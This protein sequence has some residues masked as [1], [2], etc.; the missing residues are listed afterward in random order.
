MCLRRLLKGVWEALCCQEAPVVIG[1]WNAWWVSLCGSAPTSSLHTHSCTH[2]YWHAWQHLMHRGCG[3]KKLH[4]KTRVHAIIP[5]NLRRHRAVPPL[6][7]LLCRLSRICPHWTVDTV[8]DSLFSDAFIFWDRRLLWC[9]QREETDC[10]RSERA[11]SAG[12]SDWGWCLP[13]SCYFSLFLTHYFC[14]LTVFLRDLSIFWM[15]DWSAECQV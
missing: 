15:V 10:F 8:T 9:D 12:M 7:W 6:L 13:E 4:K 5:L 14:L 1:W 2:K 11:M 3:Q